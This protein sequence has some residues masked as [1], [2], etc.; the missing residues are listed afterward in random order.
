MGCGDLAEGSWKGMKKFL[1]K[2]RLCEALQ[3]RVQYDF[4][5][6]PAFGGNSG[7]YTILLD[8][9]VVKKFGTGYACRMLTRKG[10]EIAH[11]DAVHQVPLESR[12]EYTDFELS[13]ALRD[14]RRQS[15][16]LSIASDNPM[17]R[18]FAIVDRRIGKRRLEKLKDE[19]E[20]QPEWLRV[21][22]LARMQAE[23][24]IPSGGEEAC[25]GEAD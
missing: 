6:Y 10:F 7:I 21:L 3:G 15:I 23:G 17:I 19:I 16:D 11:L 20:Q 5:W 2:D 24:V 25:G 22:Y 18:M 4:T 12:D 14:Y 9:K 8:R 13:I 1:E